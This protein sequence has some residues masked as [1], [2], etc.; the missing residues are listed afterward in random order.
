MHIEMGDDG[1]YN[2][3]RIGTI[4]FHRASSKLFQLKNLMHVPGLKKNLVSFAMLEDKGYDV[5]FSEGK[6]FLQHKATGKAKKIG[7]RVENLYRI[8]VYVI[9]T[10][11]PTIGKCDKFMQLTLEREMDLN[12]G[13]NEPQDVE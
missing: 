1:R 2:A 3:T 10:E 13:K 12:V 8:D 11:L 7:I 4:A 5:V 6:F 9:S